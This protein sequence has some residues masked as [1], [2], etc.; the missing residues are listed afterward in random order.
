MKK[1]F[2]LGLCFFILEN[3]KAQKQ[4]KIKFS[5]IN[6]VGFLTGQS[7]TM[8]TLQTVNGLKYKTWFAGLGAS[9]DNYGYRS[10]PTFIDIRK[11][12]G[13]K[14]WQP[15]IYSDAGINFPL[16]S[17]ALPRKSNGQDA[18]R[19]KNTFYEESGIG[20]SKSISK[21]IK[22]IFSAG[23][24]YKHFRYLQHNYYFPDPLGGPTLFD[25]NQQ[26]DFYY[27]R[28]SVKMGLEF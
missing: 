17:S 4:P 27:R 28:I 26:Y 24:S 11:A 9:F 23:Y 18:Y 2:F 7:Q 10:I 12:F 6:C 15:F 14:S 5:S 22:F 19:L 21:E 25:P 3:A 20:I 8:F 13:N 1:C 16:Y